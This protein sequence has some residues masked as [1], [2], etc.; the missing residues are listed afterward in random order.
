MFPEVRNQNQRIIYDI[1]FNH[2]K[3][4]KVEISSAIKTTFPFLEIL[5]DR[6]LISNDFF[7]NCQEAVRNLVPVQKVMYSVLSEM[8]KVFNIEFLDAL[9]SE[10]NMNEYPDLHTVHRNFE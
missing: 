8:E 2:F 3:R 1:V 5:R 7:E 6:E 4:Y 9:F 10:V